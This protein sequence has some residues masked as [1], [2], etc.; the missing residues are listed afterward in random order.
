[1]Q[2]GISLMLRSILHLSIPAKDIESTTQ[3]YVDGLKC[4]VGHQSSIA[5]TLNF[6]GHQ[7]VVHVSEDFEPQPKAFTLE[8]SDWF[9]GQGR[10]G[11]IFET[12]PGQTG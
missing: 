11:T 8:T 3:F 12:W 6:H 2:H 1:M 7:I 4:D 5:I 9:A 10:N